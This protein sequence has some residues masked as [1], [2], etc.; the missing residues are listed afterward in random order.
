MWHLY[1]TI[2][3]QPTAENPACCYL[4]SA[5]C[6]DILVSV[7]GSHSPALVTFPTLLTKALTFIKL[8]ESR[9]IQTCLRVLLSQY[10]GTN[11]SPSCARQLNVLRLSLLCDYRNCGSTPQANHNFLDFS[12][13]N[14]KLP[15]FPGCPGG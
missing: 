9:A 6:G 15:D 11:G 10:C 13:T 3:C 8:P 14:V 2:T 1:L 12:L 4:R 5:V 7:Q